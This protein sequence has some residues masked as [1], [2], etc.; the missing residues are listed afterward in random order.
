MRKRTYQGT[1][2][3]TKAMKKIAAP[4]EVPMERPESNPV[5]YLVAVEAFT[6]E[7]K[8][9]WLK[10]LLKSLFPDLQPQLA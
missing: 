6:E 7:K 3:L 9:G 8:V 10:K 2:V 4:A 5:A 1:C